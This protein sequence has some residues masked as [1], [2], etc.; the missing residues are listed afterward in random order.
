MSEISGIKNA[1][2]YLGLEGHFLETKLI[3]LKVYILRGSVQYYSVQF[4]K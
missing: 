3:Y 2:K 4:G 1:I